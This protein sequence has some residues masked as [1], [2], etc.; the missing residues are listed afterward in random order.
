MQFPL[1]LRVPSTL[2]EQ[3]KPFN[4]LNI[5]LSNVL[6]SHFSQTEMIGSVKRL[7]CIFSVCNP[8]SRP[9]WDL[10]SVDWERSFLLRQTK[11]DLSFSHDWSLLHFLVFLLISSNIECYDSFEF[12]ASLSVE[13]TVLRPQSIPWLIAGFISIYE[14]CFIVFMLLRSELSS[15]HKSKKLFWLCKKDG[16]WVLKNMVWE[17]KFLVDLQRKKWRST[18]RGWI[19]LQSRD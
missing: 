13:N 15:L 2:L 1:I 9:Q 7:L 16:A 6:T 5:T 10:L 19:K 8:F 18:K 11:K 17:L 4:D 14:R 12:T 3:R